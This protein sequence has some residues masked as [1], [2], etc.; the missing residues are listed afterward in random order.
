MTLLAC[1]GHVISN[2]CQLMSVGI[3][4]AQSCVI[5]ATIVSIFHSVKGVV[6]HSGPAAFLF[7]ND[8]NTF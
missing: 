3:I 1:R 5:L 6:L 2:S 8:L 4:E 7:L